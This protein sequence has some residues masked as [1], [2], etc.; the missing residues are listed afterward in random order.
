MMK[1][2]CDP[3]ARAS[4]VTKGDSFSKKKGEH[5]PEVLGATE[6]YYW[7]GRLGM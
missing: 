5:Q 2:A 4:C 6:R 1:H 7:V 3:S